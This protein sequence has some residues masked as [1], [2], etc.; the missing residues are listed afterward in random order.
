MKIF[1][2]QFPTCGTRMDVID[3]ALPVQ[4]ELVKSNLFFNSQLNLH[5]Q[6][7]VSGHGIDDENN[8]N[9]TIFL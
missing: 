1:I 7:E 4:I 6:S 8:L 2:E 5:V 9:K 3:N